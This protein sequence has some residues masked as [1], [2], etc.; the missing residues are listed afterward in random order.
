MPVER[1]PDAQAVRRLALGDAAPLRDLYERYGRVVYG[2]AY[3]LTGEA[4]LAEEAT[5]DTFVAL[6]RR[7]ETYDPERAR[8]TT[9]LFTI[10]R[11]RA[12]EL[13]RRRARLA[14]PHERPRPGRRVG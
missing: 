2:L 10:A 1:D 11:N 14:D 7:A 8:V 13:V 12:I 5:Q 4:G 9:W 3:R 6:W